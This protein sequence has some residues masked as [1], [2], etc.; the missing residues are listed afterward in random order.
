MIIASIYS[1]ILFLLNVFNNNVFA[2][3]GIQFWGSGTYT[4]LR[5]EHL[6]VMIKMSNQ[7]LVVI[8]SLAITIDC[9]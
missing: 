3:C 5:A 9:F 7:I 1:F 8:P 2:Q 6:S 4:I